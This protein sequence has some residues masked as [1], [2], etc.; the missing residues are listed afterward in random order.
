MTF[1]TRAIVFIS[2]LI[3]Y[4]RF[5]GLI[6]TYSLN[7]DTRIFFFLE[8]TNFNSNFHKILARARKWKW[9]FV[10]THRQSNSHPNKN[11]KKS[12][13]LQNCPCINF[14]DPKWEMST[15]PFFSWMFTFYITAF[16][17]LDILESIHRKNL[18]ILSSKIA[19]IPII[20]TID[21]NIKKHK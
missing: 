17:D 15:N 12:L 18:E 20:K 10:S 11:K 7:E 3:Q 9:E 19:I 13:Q 8:S 6:R 14:I 16:F 2:Q 21:D 1:Y 4:S 5:Q